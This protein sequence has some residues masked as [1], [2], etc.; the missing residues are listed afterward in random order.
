MFDCRFAVRVVAAVTTPAPCA[1]LWLRRKRD[2]QRRE[3]EPVR[4]HAV[5]RLE[6]LKVAVIGA[7]AAGL[8]TADE[9]LA[10]GHRPVVFEQ[11]AQIGGT[12]VYTDA[13]EDDPLGQKPSQRIHSSL[14]A[15]L[16]V[17]L[18]RDLMAFAGFPFSAPGLPRYPHHAD[19][20]AYLRRFATA[21]NIVDHIR[22][23]HRV[24]RIDA[25]RNDRGWRVDDEPFDAV[26]VCNGHFSEPY[27]P[28]LPG[29][30]SFPGVALHSHNYR[31]PDAFAGCRVVVLGASASGTDLAREIA[32]VARDVFLAG[33]TFRSESPRR[34]D[35]VRCCPPVERFE[36]DR[37]LLHNGEHID[38]V[39]TFLFCTGYRYAFP[40]LDESLARV[41]DNHVQDLY[42]QLAAIARPTLAFVGLPFRIVPFPLFQ[43]QARW[44]ARYLDG[45]FALPAA[46]AQ[47]RDHDAQ[48]DRRRAAGVPRH[49]FHLLGDRQVDYLNRLAAECGDEPVPEWFVTLWRAHNDNA[50]R[51]PANYRDRP[52]ADRAP[53]EASIA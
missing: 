20:L 44:F 50:R 21:R 40:F 34:G 2:A 38:A 28:N 52:L 26:A 45:R 19:V 18:P 10:A 27:V 53:S 39:Q 25:E 12:W 36:A 49:H 24:A 31:R 1:M 47:Q 7:G 35:A 48:V 32:A 4:R 16:R 5:C 11:A 23:G 33:Q 9:L 13:V 51:H 43:R 15:S 17:N 3:R 8:A 42:R 46:A 22:F 30:E 29:F 14:Y 6:H 37:V 41:R